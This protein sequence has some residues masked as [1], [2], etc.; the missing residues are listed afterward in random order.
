MPTSLV[1]HND[2]LAVQLHPTGPLEVT[3][4]DPRAFDAFLG[5]NARFGEYMYVLRGEGT[6]TSADGATLELRPGISFVA[7]PG[8]R[9]SWCVRETIRKIYVIWKMPTRPTGPEPLL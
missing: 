8:W 5:E 1:S 9:G 6:V 4:G 2:L 3:D 7:R